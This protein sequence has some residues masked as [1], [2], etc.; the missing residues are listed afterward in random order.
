VPEAKIEE[1]DVKL[2]LDLAKEM[3]KNLEKFLKNKVDKKVK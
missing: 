2:S 3:I 1:A